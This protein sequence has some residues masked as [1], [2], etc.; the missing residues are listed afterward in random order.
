MNSTTSGTMKSA[1]Q[2]FLSQSTTKTHVS[3]STQTDPSPSIIHPKLLAS[4]KNNTFELTASIWD[5]CPTNSNRYNYRSDVNRGELIDWLNDNVG[6]MGTFVQGEMPNGAGWTV[7]TDFSFDEG[8]NLK[9]IYAVQFGD[10][11]DDY[12]KFQFILNFA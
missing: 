4:A 8:R 5:Q 6:P 12:I 3:T 1:I 9:R 11:V 10:E 7:V 2:T